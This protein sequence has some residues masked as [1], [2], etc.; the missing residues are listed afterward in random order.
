MRNVLIVLSI[1]LMVLLIIGTASATDTTPPTATAC[2]PAK[3]AVNI[4][5][6]TQ[7]N[8]TFSEPIKKGTMFIEL[9]NSAGN[10]IPTTSEITSSNVVTVTPTTQLTA[11][12]T[13]NINIPHRLYN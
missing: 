7:I 2:S 8:T 4:S 12:T 3:N 9:K 5:V 10:I 11:A 1:F 6:N 13:Y